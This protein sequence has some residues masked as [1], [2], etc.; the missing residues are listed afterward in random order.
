LFSKAWGERACNVLYSQAKGEEVPLIPL[1][2]DMESWSAHESR[3]FLDVLAISA[4]ARAWGW[5]FRTASEK[6]IAVTPFPAVA[7]RHQKSGHD[8]VA[9]I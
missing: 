2:I 6:S 7:I 1:E 5:S 8:L 3:S 9:P 4:T